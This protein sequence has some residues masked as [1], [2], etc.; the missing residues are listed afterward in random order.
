MNLGEKKKSKRE[1]IIE[2]LED[3]PRLEDAPLITMK[4]KVNMAHLKVTHEKRK[5]CPKEIWK[6]KPAAHIYTDNYYME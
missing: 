4:S 3:W 6:D 1:K 2:S 5:I